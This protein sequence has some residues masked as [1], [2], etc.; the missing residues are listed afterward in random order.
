M[1]RNCSLWFSCFYGTASRLVRLFFCCKDHVYTVRSGQ[2]SLDANTIPSLP[3]KVFKISFH[4]VIS[5]LLFSLM[6]FNSWNIISL[7]ILQSHEVF[8]SARVSMADKKA[9]GF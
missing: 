3:G 6:S 2:L 8:T 5:V 1:V 7:A 4:H 9:F